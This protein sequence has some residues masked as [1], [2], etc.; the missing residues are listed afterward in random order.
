MGLKIESRHDLSVINKSGSYD[1]FFSQEGLDVVKIRI[2]KGRSLLFTPCEGDSKLTL[3]IISGQFYHVNTEQII[4]NNQTITISDITKAH[5]F[6][7]IEDVEYILVKTGQQQNRRLSLIMKANEMIEKIEQKDKY[8]EYHCDRV[9]NLS[10]AIGILMDLDNDQIRQ[11]L[12][13]SKLHD[14][15]KIDIPDEILKKDI[16]LTPDEFEIMK[17]HPV[18]GKTIIQNMMNL[19]TKLTDDDKKLF[20]NVADIIELHHEK[21][22][23]SGYP[24]HLKY[25]DLR[26]ESQILH[27]VDAY[28]AMT[29]HRVYARMKTQLEAIAELRKYAGIWYNSDIVEKLVFLLSR[30]QTNQ[31]PL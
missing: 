16:Q 22:D 2:L 6:I 17:Q 28:D 7:V 5:H 18:L 26:I 14:I 21:I 29:S 31:I 13:A 12:Y 15:G 9:G 30:I 10:V 11:L 27:V 8:T 25:P 23:G 24:H 19:E 1:V 3:Y 4:S 20:T